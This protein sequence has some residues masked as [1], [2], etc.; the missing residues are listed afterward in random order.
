[1]SLRDWADPFLALAAADK[2]PTT[3]L[4]IARRVADPT[5]LIGAALLKFADALIKNFDEI[6][7]PHPR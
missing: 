7:P 1:V 5:Q 6:F 2:S 4:S 3:D